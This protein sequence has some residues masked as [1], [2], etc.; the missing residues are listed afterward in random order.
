MATPWGQVNG[1]RLGEVPVRV[2]SEFNYL[3]PIFHF[4]FL[5]SAWPPYAPIL[6]C[7]STIVHLSSE[8]WGCA[9]YSTKRQPLSGIIVLLNLAA[10][11]LLMFGIDWILFTNIKI[12]DF[13]HSVSTLE[14]QIKEKDGHHVRATTFRRPLRHCLL[15]HCK[16]GAHVEKHNIIFSVFIS[17]TWG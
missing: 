1:S 6:I 14:T 2:L 4:S 13:R 11:I 8:R 17:Q 15:M 5:Y 16:D 12:G 7:A 9:A 10:M 3:Y